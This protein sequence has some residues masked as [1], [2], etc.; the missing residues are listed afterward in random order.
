MEVEVRLLG[1]MTMWSGL[2]VMVNRL[3]FGSMVG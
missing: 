1:L 3:N 2:L